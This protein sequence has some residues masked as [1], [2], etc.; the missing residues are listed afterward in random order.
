MRP[1]YIVPDNCSSALNTSE[2]KGVYF[3]VH[4]PEDLPLRILCGR[5]CVLLSRGMNPEEVYRVLGI[6]DVSR[7]EDCF[8][9]YNGMGCREYGQ[10]AE[11]L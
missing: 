2:G 7:F 9:A 1:L 10:W 5:A 3:S 6:E 4:V 8:T 11:S